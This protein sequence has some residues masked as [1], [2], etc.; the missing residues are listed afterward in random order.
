MLR[1]CKLCV[2]HAYARMPCSGSRHV[3]TRVCGAVSSASKDTLFGTL[4]QTLI[5][6]LSQLST[7]PTGA[8]CRSCPGCPLALCRCVSDIKVRV[9][10]SDIRLRISISIS[11]VLVS[12]L[13][14]CRAT[15]YQHALSWCGSWLRVR[16]AHT[17]GKVRQNRTQA[18][19][20]V[21][22]LSDGKVAVDAQPYVLHTA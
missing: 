1:A 19:I 4:I 15:S 14:P 22:Y 17:S 9:Y 12:V 10:T 8:C 20:Q 7:L 16:P 13:V 6:T 11:I 3:G 18:H 21:R 2:R 5:Q